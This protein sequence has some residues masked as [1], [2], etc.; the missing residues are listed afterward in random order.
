MRHI[1]D[2]KDITWDSYIKGIYKLTSP[3]GKSYVGKTTNLYA[4]LNQYK[5]LHC[6]GQGYLYNALKKYGLENFKIELLEEVQGDDIDLVEKMLNEIEIKYIAEFGVNDRSLG[7]NIAKGG[8]GGTHSEETKRKIGEGNRGK[9]RT[10]EFKNAVTARMKGVPKSAESNLKRSTSMKGKNAVPISQFTKQGEF[11]RHWDSVT[12][13]LTA[14]KMS[15]GSI[16]N[17]IAGRSKS[18]G[19]FVWKYKE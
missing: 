13:A 18:A 15:S 16:A 17:N 7:Y 14:L 1:K 2:F 6:E 10:E 4:R 9:V 19:G 8:V 11:I 5:N 3:S 12:E